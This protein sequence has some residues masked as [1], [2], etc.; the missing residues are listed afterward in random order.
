MGVQGTSAEKDL[1]DPE[2]VG[3]VFIPL[4]ASLL[5]P[6]LT[7]VAQRR[8]IQ[9]HVVP[10]KALRSTQLSNDQVLSTLLPNEEITVRFSP[11]NLQRDAARLHLT[12]SSAPIGK[13]DI[14]PWRVNRS[15]GSH[16]GV[17]V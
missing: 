13:S 12:S 15:Q 8:V 6:N 5:P 11:P 7:P 1:S 9:Y 4:N 17:R 16:P 2:F 10:G 3:T 14:T